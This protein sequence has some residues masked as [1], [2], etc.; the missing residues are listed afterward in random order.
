MANRADYLRVARQLKS[1]LNGKA[2]LSMQ[3]MYITNLVRE[4]SGEDGFRLKKIAAGEL[5][6]ELL[7]QGVRVFPSL[8][9]TSTGD[10]VRLFHTSTTVIADLVDMLTHPAEET[11]RQLADVTKKV[12]GEWV[13]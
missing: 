9:E 1:E 4:A 2:F 7:Q 11:D 6:M 8:Q 3:R 5:E 12:K 10:T 13:W